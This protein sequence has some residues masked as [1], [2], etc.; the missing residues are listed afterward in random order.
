[1][2]RTSTMNTRMRVI[3]DP[4]ELRF[5]P[6]F[7]GSGYH[8]RRTRHRACHVSRHRFCDTGQKPNAAMT[9]LTAITWVAAIVT[10]T[11]AIPIVNGFGTRRVY[12][13]M[14]A[15]APTPATTVTRTIASEIVGNG[16]PEHRV[17]HAAEARDTRDCH[18]R[19]QRDEK[20]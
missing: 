13:S 12:K 10:P 20:S 11:A 14:T 16:L 1:M 6:R 15:P 4:L 8:D 7:C 9:A 2:A 18:E 5:V 17:D 3:R 19:D